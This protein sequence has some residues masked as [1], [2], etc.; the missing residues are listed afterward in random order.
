M[1]DSFDDILAA[2]KKDDAAAKELRRQQTDQ[3]AEWEGQERKRDAAWGPLLTKPDATSIRAVVE[4]LRR[5]GLADRLVEIEAN[6]KAAGLAEV[7]PEVGRLSDYTCIDPRCTTIVLFVH[8][9]N[10]HADMTTKR[11]ELLALGLPRTA[12]VTTPESRELEAR[13]EKLDAKWPRVLRELPFDRIQEY[14]WQRLQSG[15]EL[16]A[17]PETPKVAVKPPVSSPH[18]SDVEGKIAKPRRDTPPP[19]GDTT[20]DIDRMTVT[21]HGVKYDVESLQAL[22]WVRVLASNPGKWFSASELRKHDVELDDTRTDRYK[23]KLPTRL[24]VPGRSSSISV[25]SSKSSGWTRRTGSTS[26]WPS[27]ARSTC[28][29][30]SC[31]TSRW[32]TSSRS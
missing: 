25:S 23:N 13:I 4:Y 19:K 28:I 18:E 7:R 2:K 30:R 24:P 10:R 8:E 17:E 27:F 21:F 29:R 12:K 20:V 31:P 16:P 3:Q 15:G 22:R 9:R 32:A 1:A 14:C 26:W 6:R 5:V 11:T